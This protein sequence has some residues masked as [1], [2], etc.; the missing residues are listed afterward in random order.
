MFFLFVFEK[1]KEYVLQPKT[2]ESIATVVVD[3][4][5]SEL[6]NNYVLI[7]LQKELKEKNNENRTCIIT[8]KGTPLHIVNVGYYAEH[9]L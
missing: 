3:K 9:G 5:N 1:T 2:I 4:F 6:T 8:P 7:K